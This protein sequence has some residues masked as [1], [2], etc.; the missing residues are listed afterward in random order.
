MSTAGESDFVRGLGPAYLAHILRRLS[1]R[2]IAGAAAAYPDLGVT[3][4]P[5]ATSTLLILKELG[6][7]PV[8][9]LA[10]HLRQSH[11]LVIRWIASLTELGFV[12]KRSDHEDGRRSLVALT[13]KGK[14]E[15]ER[16]RKALA[17][18]GDRTLE[19]I[20]DADAEGV[21]DALWRIEDALDEE[22]AEARFRR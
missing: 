14:R 21:I 11:P 13:E 3:T 10:K 18:V 2:L 6:P 12:E 4:P 1:D 16:V 19:L 8:T 17:V 15:V 7:L 9:V 22:A 20:A 5:R